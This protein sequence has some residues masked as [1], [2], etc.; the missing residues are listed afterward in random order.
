[1]SLFPLCV[2]GVLRVEVF[3]LSIRENLKEL[4]IWIV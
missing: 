4:Q 2:L 3:F 1:M